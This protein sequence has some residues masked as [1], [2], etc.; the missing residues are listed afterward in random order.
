MPRYTSF[1]YIFKNL[2]LGKRC[3]EFDGNHGL[4]QRLPPPGPLIGKKKRARQLHGDRACALVVRAAVRMSAH[5]APAIRMKSKPHAQ[6]A[7]VLGG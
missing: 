1:A 7:L 2:L 5:A 3:I 6:E 4:P